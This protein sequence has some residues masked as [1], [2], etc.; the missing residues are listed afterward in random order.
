MQTEILVVCVDLTLKKV[1]FLGAR[2]RVPYMGTP[3][4]GTGRNGQSTVENARH[5]IWCEILHFDPRSRI[6]YEILHFDARA[7]IWCEISH[8]DAS[9]RIWIARSLIDLAL[10]SHH[11]RIFTTSISFKI[12]LEKSAVASFFAWKFSI[13][14]CFDRRTI[15]NTINVLCT[16]LCSRVQLLIVA[17]STS[18]KFLCRCIYKLVRSSSTS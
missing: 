4:H 12:S 13:L 18:Q 3:T 15:T 6:L 14:T 16:R 7:R 2:P 9:S 17:S 8:F 11:S 10:F 1:C 5:R